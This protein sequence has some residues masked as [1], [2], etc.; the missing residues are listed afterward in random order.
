MHGYLSLFQELDAHSVLHL[1]RTIEHPTLIIAGALD[2]L[3]PAYQSYEMASRMPNSKLRIY[4][5]SSHAS[6][7]EKS[8]Q[9]VLD[10]T[11]FLNEHVDKFRRRGSSRFDPVRGSDEALLD[12]EFERMVKELEHSSSSS[13]SDSTGEDEVD[14]FKL[15]DCD[16]DAP[17]AGVH[18]LGEASSD[19]QPDLSN[20]LQLRRRRQH[21]RATDVS[22]SW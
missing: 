5:T 20:R 13:S 19:E 2:L 10:I 17:P 15:D 12:Q 9:V 7:L 18:A 6:L 1:L 11:E 8:G 14:A 4:A 16:V 22:W 3:T 21:A